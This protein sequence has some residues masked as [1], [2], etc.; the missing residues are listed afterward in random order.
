MLIVIGESPSG[1]NCIA[2]PRV[3]YQRANYTKALKKAYLLRSRPHSVIGH[4]KSQTR[5]SSRTQKQMLTSVSIARL[6]F[7]LLLR[8]INSAVPIYP[9][10]C[11]SRSFVPAVSHPGVDSVNFHS[12]RFRRHCRDYPPTCA[13]VTESNFSPPREHPPEDINQGNLPH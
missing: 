9:A 8:Q 2:T 13:N 11:T 1:R 7:V 12:V 5:R 10:T 3:E 6:F 4:M